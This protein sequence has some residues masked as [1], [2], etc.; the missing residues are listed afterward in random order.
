MGAWLNALDAHNP[1]SMH[2]TP[3]RCWHREISYVL[4]WVCLSYLIHYDRLSY[5]EYVLACGRRKECIAEL[6]SAPDYYPSGSNR[7][8]RICQYLLLLFL[9]LGEEL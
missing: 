4:D 7:N 8:L 3:K 2:R 9:R 5:G 6:A 1:Q